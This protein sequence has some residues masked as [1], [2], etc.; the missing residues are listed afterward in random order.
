MNVGVIMSNVNARAQALFSSNEQV[1]SDGA[2]QP[3]KQRGAVVG[4]GRELRPA[5][6]P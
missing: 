1:S 2:Y 5:T 6:K 3:L 4:G